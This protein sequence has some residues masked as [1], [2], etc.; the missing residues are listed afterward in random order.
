MQATM[1]DMTFED[2]PMDVKDI[3]LTDRCIAADV[4]DLLIGDE[5]RASGCVG[6]MVCDEDHRGIL[7]IVLSDVPHDADLDAL[8]RLLDLILP[9][10][11][12]RGGSLLMGRGR[13]GGGVPT[14]VDRAWHQQT[15]D[16]CQAHGVRL[17][18]F[19][20]ATRDGVTALPEPLTA[21]S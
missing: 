2:L 19:H 9:L 10:V 18:G 11:V 14:D 17:L 6:L 15:I 20:V 4:I 21:A 8:V 7:P 16:S 13:P 5:D 1:V 3:P 12:A